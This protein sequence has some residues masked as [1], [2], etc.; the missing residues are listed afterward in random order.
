MDVKKTFNRFN[1]YFSINIPDEEIC[2][3]LVGFCSCKNSI[4]IL[5]YG[6]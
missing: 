4:K 1:L 5:G 3:I 2:E 6:Q